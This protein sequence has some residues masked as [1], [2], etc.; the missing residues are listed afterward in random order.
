M[1]Y[2]KKKIGDVSNIPYV[3]LECDTLQDLQNINVENM[4]MGS[5]C[6]VVNEGATYALNSEG[7]WRKVPVGGGASSWDDLADKPFYEETTTNVIPGLNITWDGNTEGLPNFAGAGRDYVYKVSDVTPSLEQ[8]QAATIVIKNT[9]GGSD[10]VYEMSNATIKIQSEQ[11]VILSGAGPVAVVY[12]EAYGYPTGLYLPVL[13]YGA[14]YCS[15]I[16]APEISETISE[17]KTIDKKFLPEHLQFGIEKSAVNLQWDGNKDGKEVATFNDGWVDIPLYKVSDKVFTADELQNI[18][19]IGNNRPDPVE[20]YEEPMDLTGFV[21]VPFV[22]VCISGINSSMNPA[23]VS[24]GDA[25]NTTDEY[26][27]AIFPSAGTYLADMSDPVFGYWESGDTYVPVG[28]ITSVKGE[29]V[30]KTIDPKYLPEALQLGEEVAL[31]E[32]TSVLVKS[33]AN[34][35]TNFDLEIAQAIFDDHSNGLFVVDDISYP[36]S[37]CKIEESDTRL[38]FNIS[39]SSNAGFYL[40]LDNGKPTGDLWYTGFYDTPSISI[41]A[42]VEQIVVKKLDAKY[43]PDDIGSDDKNKPIDL[44]VDVDNK[45]YSCEFSLDTLFNKIN[46]EGWGVVNPKLVNSSGAP[47]CFGY[48]GQYLPNWVKFFY[49]DAWTSTVSQVTYNKLRVSVVTVSASSGISVA[50]HLTMQEQV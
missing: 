24:V 33:G 20:L 14:M 31:V 46:N 32:K 9:T 29:D 19:V 8:L 15:S 28:Y 17:V 40:K 50:T 11:V 45:T 3:T 25:T 38:K 26:S 41:T 49:L 23:L 44:I 35:G 48:F 22:L 10:S 4:I 43:L 13:M 16:T 5:R 2:I 27:K 12:D 47:V 6:Y 34:S 21:G 36:L 42:M 39:E 18:T 1:S 7:E 30:V 37:D